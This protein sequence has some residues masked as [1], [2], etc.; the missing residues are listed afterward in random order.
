MWFYRVWPR[1]LFSRSI[2]SLSESAIAF[3][4][5]CVSSNSY[6]VWLG[7]VCGTPK[8]SC[9]GGRLILAPFLWRLF[10]VCVFVWFELV[11]GVLELWRGVRGGVLYC[12]N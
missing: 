12:K 2:T 11:P 3:M 5:F 1:V 10:T 6:V 9:A 7:V 4:N 8:V